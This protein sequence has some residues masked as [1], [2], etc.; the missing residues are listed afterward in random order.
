M[1]RFFEQKL[2]T[3][4]CSLLTCSFPLFVQITVAQTTLSPTDH[5]RDFSPQD[6]VTFADGDL[7]EVVRDALEIGAEDPLT[8]AIASELQAL[9]VGTSIQRVVYGGTLRQSP[10]KPFEDLSGIQNLTG[11]TRLAIINRL[12]TDI[13]PISSLTNLEFLSLH[14]NWFSDITPLANLTNLEQLIIS[15]NPI[16]DISPLANLT[17]L[18]RLHVHGLYPYQLEHYL[19]YD[20][21]RDPNVV[22][23]GIT[24][25]SPLA[26]LTELRLLRIHLNSISDISPLANLTNMTHLR[27]YDN[28]IEDISALQNMDYLILLWAHNNQIKDIGPLA[29]KPGMLQLSLNDN[30]IES[31]DPLSRMEE[32]EYLFLSNNQISDIAPL[33][34]LHALQ[35]LR[36]ENNDITDVS[37]IAA[38]N[39]LRELS[40]AQNW[41]LFNVRPLLLNSALGEG[42]ELDLRYTYVRCSD[43]DAFDR[44]G[45]DLLRIT[46]IN[47]S[48]CDGRRLE[49]P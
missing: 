44:L 31:L 17:K 7:E 41:S 29:N 16:S 34:R 28:Q 40:L 10:D 11:L 23:N 35:V 46:A 21:G 25:V 33:R 4:F 36:L 9:N 12:I 22:F 14:T 18:R 27:I 42:F 24:D 47:G 45:V 3:I 20:D 48:A 13:S 30:A 38:M 49:D 6:I 8:C 26:N 1:Q 15:E 5:C 2:V 39:N 19:N 43:M 37:A 32:L